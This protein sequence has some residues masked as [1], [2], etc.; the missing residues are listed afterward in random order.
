MPAAV[1]PVPPTAQQAEK[2]RAALSSVLAAAGIT[3]LKL[4]AGIATHSLGML[5]EAAHSG[6]DLAAAGIT[7]FSV[8]VS[9]KPADEDHN[10]GHGKIENLSSFVETFLMG[11]SCLW[12]VLE[13]V[14]RLLHP[15]VQRR[16]HL[17]R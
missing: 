6:L 12:I 9:D 10:F 16:A 15:G 13:A 5:S 17:G 8:Q 11:A 4:I 3:A 2:R 14:R 1:Q 7:L